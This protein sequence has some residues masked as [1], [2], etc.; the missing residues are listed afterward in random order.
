MSINKNKSTQKLTTIYDEVLFSNIVTVFNEYR[1]SKYTE[2]RR[3]DQN[4]FRIQLWSKN[5]KK[6][7]RDC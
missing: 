5:G 1:S 4:G 3:G 7:C 6:R 2:Q